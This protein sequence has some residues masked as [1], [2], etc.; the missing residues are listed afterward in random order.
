MFGA[1]RA[2]ARGYGRRVSWSSWRALSTST[3]S[4][5]SAPSSTA[6]VCF[7]IDGVLLRGYNPL[8]HA[9]ESLLRLIDARIPFVFL[10]NGGGE[11]ESTKREKLSKLLA[12]PL[13]DEQIILS[14]TPLK[15]VCA[16]YA[17][18]RVLVLG[19]RD[20]VGV[21]RSYGL[22]RMVTAA[23]LCRDDPFRYPFLHFPHAPIAP[24]EARDPIEAVMILHDPNEWS[25]E[26]QVTLDV[27]RGGTPLGSGLGGLR[28]RAQSIPLFSSNSDLL[29]AGVYPVPRLAAGAYTVALRALWRATTGE[30]LE[31][32]QYGKPMKVTFDFALAHLARWA[33]LAEEE[34]WYGEA[35]RAAAR[36]TPEE[37]SGSWA[38]PAAPHVAAAAEGAAAPFAPLPPSPPSA[39]ARRAGDASA[40]SAGQDAAAAHEARGAGARLHPVGGGGASPPPSP[41]PPFRRV[42]MIGDNP[43]AD[44]KG[45]N[46]AGG[47]W[48]SILVRTGVFQEGANDAVNPAKDVVQGVREAVDVVLREAGR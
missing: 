22:R 47:P 5:S 44:I 4:R 45:A 15:P 21:G 23:A 42:F 19:C 3:P 28:S 25:A 37:D 17:D 11:L 13:R 10:T 1:S 12:L 31:V 20:V 26:L 32:T 27:L 38:S 18:K 29:F 6:A 8:P 36:L 7:D 48:H 35:R 24:D 43:R 30:E 34:D 46:D 2:A 41:Q 9:R 14:H 39:S 33:R 16:E 40:T